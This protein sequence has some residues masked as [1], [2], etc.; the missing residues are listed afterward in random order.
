MNTD[1]QLYL[2]TKKERIETELSTLLTAKSARTDGLY[3]AMNYS[4]LAGGKRIRPILLLTA[5]EVL[6]RPS[7]DY[8][9]V[10]CAVECVHTY[11]LI[12]DDLPCMDN[13]DYRRGKLTC[14][15]QFTPAIATLAGDALLT[16]AFELISTAPE[17]RSEI[18]LELIR[19]LAQAAGPDGMVGGQYIDICASQENNTPE[20][21][22]YMDAKKTG[23]LLTAPLV[24]AGV[25]AEADAAHKRTL[26]QYGEAI[27]LL[28][29]IVD[30]LLDEQGT[31]EEMG[32]EQ[33][34][35]RKMGKATYVTLLGREEAYRRAE[36][37]AVRAQEILAAAGWGHTVLSKFPTYLLTRVK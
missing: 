27:G 1:F 8:L 30:D 32:K 10:G 15:K 4:L 37:Q 11:S 29:Q 20:S 26:V 34:Q 23:C 2:Q 18:R 16:I 21:L 28:F 25:I 14:H 6:G 7:P 5:L 9:S 17:L 36:V 24:M 13:D 3:A 19:I 31:L 12:H 33:G 22:Q 35:D